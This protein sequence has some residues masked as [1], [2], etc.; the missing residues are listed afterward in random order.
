M[1]TN[2]SP[3][4]IPMTGNKLALRHNSHN[5]LLLPDG[6][7]SRRPS[8]RCLPPAAAPGE[9]EHWPD[10]RRGTNSAAPLISGRLHWPRG[11]A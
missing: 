10:P 7:G 2:R 11:H 9:S 1:P 3:W 6:G 8:P 4:H 5:W